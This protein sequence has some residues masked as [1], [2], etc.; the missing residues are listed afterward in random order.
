MKSASVN[1]RLNDPIAVLKAGLRTVRHHQLGW[2]KEDLIASGTLDG[3]KEGVYAKMF[4]NFQAQQIYIGAQQDILGEDFNPLHVLLVRDKEGRF[5]FTKNIDVPKNH[6]SIA[7][8]FAR[9]R[10]QFIDL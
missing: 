7:Y 2:L 8:L 4:A 3:S 1:L 5:S 10:H 9:L 6:L